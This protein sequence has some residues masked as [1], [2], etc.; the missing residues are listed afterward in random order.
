MTA[1]AHD[2]GS[3]HPAAAGVTGTLLHT[4]LVAAVAFLVIGMVRTVA[5]VPS[6]EELAMFPSTAD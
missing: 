5:I 4:W 6:S 2:H 1:R 3:D